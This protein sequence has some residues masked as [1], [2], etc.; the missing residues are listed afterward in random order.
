M[1][2][3]NSSNPIL[4]YKLDPG[5]WGSSAPAAASNSISRVASHESSNLG[6]FESKANKDNCYIVNKSLYL[7]LTKRGSYLAATS[8][9]S[10]AAIYCPKKAK[11]ERIK[12]SIGS[13]ISSKLK[14]YTYDEYKLKIMLKAA[15]NDSLKNI[16][17]KDLKKIEARKLTLQQKKMRIY[18]Q[19]TLLLAQNIKF[20]PSSIDLSV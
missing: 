17:E 7:N 10:Q 14:K 19:V 12:S 6:R 3:V 11:Q 9:H 8:G 13:K 16:Y 5:E 20:D 1:L 4:Q 2:S 18:T 15:K